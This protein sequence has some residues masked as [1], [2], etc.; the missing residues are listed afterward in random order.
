MKNIREIIGDNLSTLRKERKLTQAEIAER[1][2]YSD[3]AVSKWE[4]GDTSPDIE[5]LNALAQFYG[6]TLDYL[7]SE[8]SSENKASYVKKQ[9]KPESNKIASCALAA[10]IVWIIATIIYVYGIINKS[11]NG[12]RL[13]VSFAWS[14]PPTCIIVLFFDARYFK[15]RLLKLVLLST[16]FWS[17]ITASYLTIGVMNDWTL[18]PVFI[19]GVPL[20]I[21]LILWYQTKK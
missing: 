12:S 18:W 7:I 8:D 16:M 13:W 2:N 14:I 20:Q 11:D 9:N 17:I 5:T 21:S 6:V 19:I 10:S 15:N 3:K 1:F 4:N